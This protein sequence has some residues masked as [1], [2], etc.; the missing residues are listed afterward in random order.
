[1]LI[2]VILLL[3]ATTSGDDITVS[4]RVTTE[5]G[6]VLHGADIRLIINNTTF[7]ARSGQDGHYSL[8]ISG[9]YPGKEAG[10]MSWP[11]FPNPS[12]GKVR[13]PVAIPSAGDLQFSV[14]SHNGIKIFEKAFSNM[15]AGSYR[16]VWNGGSSSGTR[17]AAGIYIYALTHNGQ[18][19]S[20]RVIISGNRQPGTGKAYT[21]PFIVPEGT[22]TDNLTSQ[23][24]SA[25]ATVTAE[26]YHTLRHTGIYLHTDTLMDFRLSA[27]DNVPFAIEGDHIGKR[28]DNGYLAMV[29]KGINL[30]SAPPG[31]FPGEIAYSINAETYERWIKMMAETG[32]NA[33]RVYT[34]HPPVFYEK[35][36]EYNIENP[37]KP[38]FLFQGIW[39]DEITDPS[40][41]SEYDLFQRED[42]LR[43][44]IHEVLDC[45]HGN[46][47]IAFRP[48][49]AYG[50]YLTD[51]SPWIAGYIIGREVAPQEIEATNSMNS[52]ITGYT[53]QRFSISD[54]PASEVFFTSMLDETVSYEQQQYSTRRPVSVSSW[55]T[56]DPLNHP[57]ETYTDEDIATMDITLISEQGDESLLFA[58]YHAYPYYPDFISM[59]PGY[60][61]YSDDSGPNSYYAYLI[62]LRDYYG[63]I[64]LIIAEFG[65]PSSRGNAHNSFSG[66]NHGGNNEIQQGEMNIRMMRNILNAGCGGGFMFSWMDEWFKP[67]WIVEYL[68]ASG[69]S[70]GGSYI[71]TRQLWHNIVSP[72]Q[73]F[74]LI[75]FEQDD[76]F[77]E[78]DY[79]TGDPAGTGINISAG[80]NNRFLEINIDTGEPVTEG[81]TVIIAIDSYRADLGESVLPGDFA[82]A[83]RAEFL[84]RCIRSRDSSTLFVTEAY[85]MKGVTPRF[86]LSNP[87][88]QK[89]QS[90]VSDGAPWKRVEWINNGFTGDTS[91]PGLIA[92]GNGPFPKQT[93]AEGVSWYESRLTVRLPWTLLNFYD[94][95]RMAV[96]DGA[97]SYDGGYSLVIEEAESDGIALSI[98]KGGEMISTQSR[99]S[100]PHWSVVPSTTE[101]EKASLGIVREGLTTIPDYSY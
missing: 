22:E 2:L 5:S 86:N 75:S 48:G 45:M 52:H 73:N 33:V 63:S 40:S 65:V 28:D 96:I 87:D 9:V 43:N 93:Y 81:D 58:S 11:P 71:S 1:M 51:I 35:L 79:M 66:M 36:Y 70:Q 89:Y 4:G 29:L 100:W 74:G 56:L 12:S 72:E 7:A 83:N 8:T 50:S 62:N 98:I 54:A 97:T 25:V 14:Y 46:R 49:R 95:T 37:G 44:D 10:F 61:D 13:I 68:E 67:T 55:P 82:T 16:I 27:Y 84:L 38:L 31:F 85:D 18:T 26:G 101:R 78:H 88:V 34:L 91:I 76:A 99:Y 42:D 32:F 77:P 64:P 30:G 92:T 20:G 53:G 6:T 94:P 3:P 60:L 80:G 59:E 90:V 39:L 21:E 15:S 69:Y 41:A 24:L 57:T 23:K 19:L 17:P 47:N